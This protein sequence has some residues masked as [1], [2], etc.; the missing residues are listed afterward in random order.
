MSKPNDPH[1]NF[2]VQDTHGSRS[3]SSQLDIYQE[4]VESSSKGDRFLEQVN[5]GLGNYS[6]AEYWQQM[7]AFKAGMYG[8]EAFSR[9]LLDRAIHQTKMTLAREGAKFEVNVDGDP[10]MVDVTGW[11]NLNE[12]QRKGKDRRRYIEQRAE[13]IWQN[14]PENHRA[15]AVV[16]VTGFAT[17]WT[18]PHFAMVMAR[19]EASRSRDARL[20]DNLFDRVREIKDQTAKE[21]KST[22]QRLKNGHQ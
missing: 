15:E 17:E 1:T 19:H 11:A 18:P 12:E 9:V 10:K 2:S 22:M 13:E 14:L 5:L 3:P 6:S 16:E 20:L 8:R 21:S 4:A 7:D